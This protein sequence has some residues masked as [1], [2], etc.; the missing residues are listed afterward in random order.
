MTRILRTTAATAPRASAVLTAVIRIPI[1]RRRCVR[2]R[3]TAITTAVTVAV[4]ARRR[5]TAAVIANQYVATTATTRRRIAEQY[6]QQTAAKPTVTVGM[7]TGM[8]TAVAV[9]TVLGILRILR[10]LHGVAAATEIATVTVA[11]IVSS[12][13]VRAASVRITYKAHSISEPLVYLRKNLILQYMQY[14]RR[15]VNDGHICFHFLLFTSVG[16]AQL[17]ASNSH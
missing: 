14:A 12:R 15:Y 16:Y 2:S 6:V 17:A 5:R 1:R 11:V 3:I 4:R 7:T 13:G 10:I 8:T 9:R